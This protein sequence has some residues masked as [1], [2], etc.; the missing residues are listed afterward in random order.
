MVGKE[1]PAPTP[2][3]AE[4]EMETQNTAEIMSDDL[5]VLS[6]DDQKFVE[7]LFKNNIA[8][9]NLMS[10]IL[11]DDLQN[12]QGTGYQENLSEYSS[13]EEAII[14]SIM[15]KININKYIIKND[16]EWARTEYHKQLKKEIFSKKTLSVIITNSIN[17][18]NLYKQISISVAEDV[19]EYIDN[20]L[21]SSL[22]STTQAMMTENILTLNS[23]SIE[24]Q[25]NVIKAL[26]VSSEES[27]DKPK[28]E[29]TRKETGEGST[30]NEAS[31]NETSE[32]TWGSKIENN[33]NG[34]ISNDKSDNWSNGES[35][36]DSKEKDKSNEYVPDHTIDET[37]IYII[38]ALRGKKGKDIS[39]LIPLT[40]V[41]FTSDEWKGFKWRIS[42][43]LCID[44]YNSILSE[45]AYQE[46][47][48][49]RSMVVTSST[50][51][52]GFL[53]SVK[54]YLSYYSKIEQNTDAATTLSAQTDIMYTKLQGIFTRER[55]D[56]MFDVNTTN[57][58]SQSSWENA[59][60]ALKYIKKIEKNTW[61]TSTLWEVELT[62]FLGKIDTKSIVTV[63]QVKNLTAQLSI[64]KKLTIYLSD[65]KKEELNT[66][67]NDIISDI[68]LSS[69]T[70]SLKDQVTCYTSIDKL[71]EENET[72]NADKEDD[73]DESGDASIVQLEKT[74]TPIFEWDYSS[75]P[76]LKTFVAT[77]QATFNKLKKKQITLKEFQTSTE[78]LIKTNE[79]VFERLQTIMETK[80]KEKNDKKE[81][82]KEKKQS[83]IM[84]SWKASIIGSVTAGND[85]S[86][87]EKIDPKN[88][89]LPQKLEESWAL[90][91]WNTNLWWLN[92]TWD[93]S[94]LSWTTTIQKDATK[95]I[96]T[97]EEEIYY[98]DNETPTKVNIETIKMTYRPYPNPVAKDGKLNINLGVNKQSDWSALFDS[99]IIYG[100]DGREVKKMEGNG[101]P[102]DKDSNKLSIDIQQDLNVANWIYFIQLYNSANS[103][104]N[105][106]AVKKD[107]N[108]SI[109]AQ[110]IVI[111]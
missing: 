25:N 51:M 52:K 63:D 17:Y 47:K 56:L 1:I 4:T 110:K 61:N 15:S 104:I 24:E 101:V 98:Q 92:E 20:S 109:G 21:Q 103:N 108:T 10:W 48:A 40:K 42:S 83:P 71:F 32:T 30:T 2:T 27:Q 49:E 5:S 36:N 72:G 54:D 12:M 57:T 23:L 64:A 26:R 88:P 80:N 22:K 55:N 67:I 78:S 11:V 34:S 91:W 14:Q 8:Q 66:K 69:Q 102:Y 31:M 44:K 41:K 95:T 89:L 43:V 87:L 86:L 106:N 18:P 37:K 73:E 6:D 60:K 96:N 90:G 53:S 39:N 94:L 93:N 100:V 3:T 105:L 81:K 28:E 97:S 70:M 13:W 84:K 74:L 33:S 85:L 7:D 45:P 75:D 19:S 38:D 9:I 99:Y 29:W 79:A 35:N 59:I 50:W 111:V 62:E 77:I 107:E 16:K 65:T 46:E 68:Y 76:E 82:E 58:E